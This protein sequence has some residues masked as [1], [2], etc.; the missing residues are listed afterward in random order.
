MKQSADRS[1]E[2]EQYG[3]RNCLRIHGVEVADNETSD[4]VVKKVE[5]IAAEVGVTLQR[6]DIFRAH[7]IGKVVDK[8]GKRQNKSLLNSVRGMRAVD[9]TK[10]VLLSRNRFTL[11]N[12]S[13]LSRSI[14]QRSDYLFF[15]RRGR[16]SRR[17]T[18][19]KAK[20]LHMLT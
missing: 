2:L 12:H 18:E 20:Y 4:D 13:R 10:A 19:K 7:R 6:D 14:L 1:E 3:R 15:T 16:L 17:N 11:R 8:K 5:S 9:Y